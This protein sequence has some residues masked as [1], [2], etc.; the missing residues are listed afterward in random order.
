MNTHEALNHIEILDFSPLTIPEKRWGKY[1][2]F[3]KILHFQLYPDIAL[4]TTDESV[5]KGV[6]LYAEH[7]EV[8][9]VMFSI[10]D[11]SFHKQVGHILCVIPRKTSE[12]YQENKGYMEFYI[13]ILENYHRKGIGTKALVK[14]FEVAA[15]NEKKLLATDTYFAS[16][17]AFLQDM[18]AELE[19]G[20]ENRLRLDEIDWSMIQQWEKEGEEKSS[21]TKLVHLN[22]ISEEYIE[23]FSKLYTETY[24]QQP[25][26]GLDEVAISFTP[27][28][29]RHRKTSYEQTGM[30]NNIMFTVEEDGE[31]S[32]LT[33]MEYNP[34][35]KTMITQGL[36]GVKEEHRGRGLGKWL[37][38]SMLL[39][40]QEQYPE[41]K[42]VRT[43][44]VTSNAPML[45]INN[46]LGFK[47][48]RESIEAQISLEKL[49]QYLKSKEAIL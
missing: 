17:K 30:K 36:T 7:P 13:N 25:V 29:F 35:L 32:G 44:N 38:A 3:R 49:K 34:G 37:K 15:E 10:M 26:E 48:H 39:K 40:I 46:R 16:G 9:G 4:E 18:D 20:I 45:S 43:E 24:S 1:H 6:K 41:V 21:K 27:E 42:I 28:Y 5:E 22:N 14:V 23:Q 33:E 12:T 31:I 47:F 8:K 19:I 2:E 11:K